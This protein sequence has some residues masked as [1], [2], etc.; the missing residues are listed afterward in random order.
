MKTKL[1]LLTAL[2]LTTFYSYG[3]S[4]SLTYEGEVLE[5]NQEIFVEGSY[6]AFEIVAEILV[7]NNSADSMEVKVR[8]I[9]NFLVDSTECVFCWGLCFPPF[10]YESP[11]PITIHA[12]E[13][14]DMFSG[15]YNPLE[16][17]GQSTVSFVFFDMENPNDSVM[18]VIIFEGLYTD[19]DEN[20]ASNFN[21]SEPYPNPANNNVSFNYNND[22]IRDAQLN[23]YSIV[24]SLVKEIKLTNNSGSLKINT[25]ELKEGFYFYKLS[26]ENREI[27]SGKFIIKH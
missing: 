14:S 15:H 21:I 7:T 17:A 22:G 4:L 23:I 10:V 1:L 16:H 18:V 26:S 9:E 20:I 5:P 24:G 13:T 2:F 12:G 11:Y 6:S 3:Q 8:K 19:V 25:S 27:E